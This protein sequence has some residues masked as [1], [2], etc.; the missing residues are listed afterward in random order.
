MSIYEDSNNILWI[1][2]WRGA[3][4]RFDRESRTFRHYRHDPQNPQSLSDNDVSC[5]YEAPS[6]PGVLWIGTYKGGLNRF[7]PEREIFQR[8]QHDPQ[9]LQSLSSNFIN[10]VH[11]DRTGILWIG[12]A[13]G[14]NGFD[15][16]TQSV[17]RYG[18]AEGL[19]NE[20]VLGILED[21]R[22]NLWLST[23]NGLSRFNL[24]NRTFKNYD[25]RD[26]LQSNVFGQNAYC[27]LRSGEMV[28]GGMNGFNIFHP[29]SVKDNPTIPPVVFTG[30]TRYSTGSN[31]GAVTV[32]KGI[33]EKEAVEFSYQENIFTL[34]FAALNFRLPQKNQYAYKLEG[35]SDQWIQLGNKHDITFTNL[36]PGEYTLRVKGSNNDGIWNEEGATLKIIIHPPWWETPGGRTLFM[37]WL[38]QRPCTA[39][40]ALN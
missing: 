37:P 39:S 11:E 33:S 15:R 28:F 34:E 22:G 4:H 36:D 12:T 5:I 25:V 23:G 24:E 38:W 35:F 31:E 20:V 32:E 19:P 7:D 8:Y 1:G 2:T 13:S 6:E 30:L 40:G 29:D 3:L 18:E 17:S 27:K 10:T 16:E 21:D 14:L 26:G 9:N